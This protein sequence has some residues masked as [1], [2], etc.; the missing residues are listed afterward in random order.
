[1]S[2][3]LGFVT[4]TQKLTYCIGVNPIPEEFTPRFGPRYEKEKEK[5]GCGA[6]VA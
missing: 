3:S 1:M 5:N 2:L 6:D 4:R